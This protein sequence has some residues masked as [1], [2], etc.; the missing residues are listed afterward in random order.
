MEP[1][2]LFAALRDDMTRAD[3]ISGVLYDAR[4]MAASDDGERGSR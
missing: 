1:H 2:P 3:R 4:G